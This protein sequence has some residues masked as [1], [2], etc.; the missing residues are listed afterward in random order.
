MASKALDKCLDLTL[1]IPYTVGAISTRP[2]SQ[3]RKLQLKEINQLPETAAGIGV[4]LSTSGFT[5]L[6]HR[7]YPHTDIPQHTH[8]CAHCQSYRWEEQDPLPPPWV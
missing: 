1:L 4:G 2:I 7:S 3:M 5:C 8:A 6:M